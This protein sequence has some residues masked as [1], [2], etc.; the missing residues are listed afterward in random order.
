M[1]RKKFITTAVT[2]GA[3]AITAKG[4]SFSKSNNQAF[5]VKNKQSRFNEKTN[6][7][8]L[9]DIKVSTKDT[10]GALSIFEYTSTIKGGPPLHIHHFQ[11][12][13]FF[14]QQGDYI[15]QVGDEK[16]KLTAGDTI[17]LPRNVPH[18]FA[19]VSDTGKLFYLFNPAGKME[20]FFRALGSIKGIPP[21]AVAAKIFEAHDMKIVGP[22]LAY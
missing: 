11:D 5:V 10:G 4:F 8:G 17:F 19:Q 21:P 7:G 18:A 16:H 13:I 12:E 9:N 1:Q 2:A 22:P 20:D 15:F 6:V 3:I 14:I